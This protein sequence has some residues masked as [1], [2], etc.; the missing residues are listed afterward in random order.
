MIKAKDIMNADII[1]VD[2]E[3]SVDDVLNQMMDTYVDPCL[4]LQ[5]QYN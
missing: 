5:Q 1:T 2:P 3:D 4:K